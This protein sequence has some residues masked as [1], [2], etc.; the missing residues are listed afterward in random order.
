VAFGKS[1]KP[2]VTSP[3]P[4]FCWRP[5][6][7]NPVARPETPSALLATPSS[8]MLASSS[9]LRS[10]LPACT[11]SCTS[12]VRVRRKSRSCR[13]SASG[14]KLTSSAAVVVPNSRISRFGSAPAPSVGT[15]TAT[16]SYEH[17]GPRSGHGESLLRAAFPRATFVG[18][19]GVPAKLSRA[20]GCP[21]SCSRTARGFAR[22]CGYFRDADAVGAGVFRNARN[23]AGSLVRLGNF[24][25][26]FSSGVMIA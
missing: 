16:L 18:T 22:F 19:S 20:R 5:I 4:S 25:T 10:R 8:L 11:H 14:T 21:R 3:C 13:I 17:P 12:V 23:S 7:Y 24:A 26:T 1:G 2:E 9:T 6:R 15:H